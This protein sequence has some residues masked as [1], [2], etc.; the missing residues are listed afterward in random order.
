MLDFWDP[1]PIYRDQKALKNKQPLVECESRRVF[2]RKSQKRC[3]LSA[4]K[5]NWAKSQKSAIRHF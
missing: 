3:A 4:P 5:E 2:L 1:D